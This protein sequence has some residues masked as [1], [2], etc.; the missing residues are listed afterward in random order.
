MARV[1][2]AP[3]GG[4]AQYHEGRYFIQRVVEPVR[5]ERRAMTRLMPARVR[6]RGVK[7]AIDHE[8]HDR[9]QATRLPQPECHYSGSADQRES[10]HCVAHSGPVATLEQL[11]D[12]VFGH[13][14]Y[15][16]ARAGQTALDREG[17]VLAHQ[18]IVA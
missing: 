12:L 11:A 8:W 14:R 1:T 9:P 2:P 15:V 5:P 13:R 16:P 4:F 18:A 3:D 6:T 17:P 7:N 10:D